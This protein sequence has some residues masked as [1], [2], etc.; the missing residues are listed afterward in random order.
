M[1]NKAQQCDNPN[2]MGQRKVITRTKLF[3]SNLQMGREIYFM[4]AYL[5]QG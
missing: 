5:N 4:R 2:N 1:I 3:E